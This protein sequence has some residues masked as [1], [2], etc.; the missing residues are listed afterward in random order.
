MSA[1]RE[2]R[3]GATL[4]NV[5]HPDLNVT[6]NSLLAQSAVGSRGV[7]LDWPSSQPELTWD[8]RRLGRPMLGA[9]QIDVSL[10]SG[11]HSVQWTGRE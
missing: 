4:P 2:L 1:H 6:A 8:R 5:P 10:G 7:A 3:G 9:G 11:D